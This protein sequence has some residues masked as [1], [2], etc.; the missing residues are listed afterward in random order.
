MEDFSW[1][2]WVI[3]TAIST[4]M[5][6][7]VYNKRA[8]FTSGKTEAITASKIEINSNLLVNVIKE[9]ETTK[10]ELKSLY[11][12]FQESKVNN[13]KIAEKLNYLIQRVDDLS[14]QVKIYNDTGRQRYNQYRDEDRQDGDDG[15]YHGRKDDHG[16]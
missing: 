16:R 8:A 1:I 4:G 13:V 12:E 5:A 2:Q 11:K 9:L 14:E 6:I 10:T 7:F 3:P 15:I